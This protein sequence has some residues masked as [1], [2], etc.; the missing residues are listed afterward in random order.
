MSFRKFL[1]ETDMPVYR[2]FEKGE[3]PT[4]GRKRPYEEFGFSCEVSD[5]EW[6]DLAG[7]IEDASQFLEKHRTSIFALRNTCE[8]DDL[9]LDFPYSLR[10]DEHVCVQCDYLPPDFLKL[11]GE[12][13][14]GIAM[15]LYPPMDEEDSEQKN[16][17]DGADE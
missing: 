10:L 2:S 9:R 11:A 13:G 1:E 16:G 5:R 4:T 15:S 17:A 8:V 7:Q 6:T 12:M 3:I 14:I